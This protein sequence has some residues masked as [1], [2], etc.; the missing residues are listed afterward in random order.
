MSLLGPLLAGFVIR[1]RAVMYHP[2]TPG[3]SWVQSPVSFR[4]EGA[5]GGG[6]GG[7]GEEKG[8]RLKEK[9][10]EKKVHS[11]GSWDVGT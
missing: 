7:V 10:E 6:T 8:R 3:Q 1:G 9:T 4:R 5:G 11:R 2:L